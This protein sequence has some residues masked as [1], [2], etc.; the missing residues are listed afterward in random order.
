[1]EH[2][3]VDLQDVC[4]A[5]RAAKA[6]PKAA[7]GSPSVGGVVRD[8]RI[9]LGAALEATVDIEDVSSM[10]TAYF[11]LTNCI[12]VKAV[13]IYGDRQN[14]MNVARASSVMHGCIV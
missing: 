8:D 5:Q 6:A 1:M 12:T 7:V 3:P 14:Q 2:D 9:L 4:T 13:L 11:P 10:Q